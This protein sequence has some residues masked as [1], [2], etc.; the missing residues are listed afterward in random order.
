M[1]NACKSPL[2]RFE[3]FKALRDLVDDA[4]RFVFD[5]VIFDADFLRR[6][7]NFDVV[8]L[9]GA[10][11]DVVFNAGAAGVVPFDALFEVF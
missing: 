5:E 1:L 4:R 7:Q 2:N 10:E 9:T 3:I 6:F 8:R 11:R